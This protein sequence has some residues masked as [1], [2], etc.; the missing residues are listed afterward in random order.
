MQNIRGLLRL[1][2]TE[3][4]TEQRSA[5]SQGLQ[6][7]ARHFASQRHH[8]AICA[9][10]NVLNVGEFSRLAQNIGDLLGRFDLMIRHVNGTNQNVFALQHR[11]E[12]HGHT[13]V[14]AFKTHLIDGTFC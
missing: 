12:F 2:Q 11:D 13:R 6:F 10:I 8:P 1:V 5:C 9:T 3:F 7:G 14:D 4:L